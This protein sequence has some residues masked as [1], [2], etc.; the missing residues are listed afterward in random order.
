MRDRHE[1][2]VLLV[3]RILQGLGGG[4]MAP[5]DRPS[6]RHLSAR[7]AAGLRTYGIAV[8]FAPTIGPTLG[9]WITDNYS[10]HWIFF[11]NLPFG[12]LSL[13]LVQWLLVEPEA[14][15]RERS[16]R[17]AG[18]LTVDWVGFILVA[19]F[20]GCLEIVLDTG[21]A[22]RLVRLEFYRRLQR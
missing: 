14:L 16:E 5:S 10:W 1:F 9:G 15:E 11:I 20:L 3:F 21:P 6:S 19:L 2:A 18:G 22:R 7:S 8:V 17:L 13:T 4:G 12:I